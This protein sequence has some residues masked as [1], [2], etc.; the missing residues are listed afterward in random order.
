MGLLDALFGQQAQVPGATQ[1]PTGLQQLFQPQTAMPMA[2]ALLGGQGDAKNFGNAFAAYGQTKAQTAAQNRT[3]DYFNKNA[4]EYAQMV[5]AGMPVEEAWKTYTQQK[6]AQKQGQGIVNAG[7]GNLYDSATKTWLSAPG[8]GVESKAGLTPVWLRDTKTGKPVLGQM[9]QDGSI[10]RSSID[11]NLEPISPYDVNFDKASGTAAGTG[12]GTAAAALPGAT[13]LANKISE[14]VSALKTD[15]YLPNML[16][17]INSHLPNV[18]S[19][20]ARVQSKITQLSGEAFL[21]ARQA[22]KGGGAI[23]D[24]EGQ[25]AEEALA[26]MN[27]AQSVEDF[28]AALDEFNQHVQMGLQ[29]LQQ[30]AAQRPLYQG[31]GMGQPQQGMAPAAPSGGMNQTSSGVKWSV[32]P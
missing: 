3:M 31:G 32:A 11:Q 2:A 19:D 7:G 30:Q 6:Y 8:G 12:A 10:V 1:Q 9:R 22:L 23:T 26:R 25:K 5:A 4:P 20:A 27:Q 14:Q 13:S 24:Y 15:A 18:S 17:P 16:G 29:I 21:T 28:N